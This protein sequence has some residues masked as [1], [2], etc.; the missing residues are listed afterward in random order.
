MISIQSILAPSLKISD[1]ENIKTKPVKLNSKKQEEKRI[2]ETTT[3]STIIIIDDKYVSL[4]I[5]KHFGYQKPYELNHSI[6]PPKDVDLFESIFYWPKQ[7]YTRPELNHIVYKTIKE[8]G[9]HYKSQLIY[10]LN[11]EVIDV[12]IK[13]GALTLS[14]KER[15]HIV[16]IPPNDSDTP[17]YDYITDDGHYK[18]DCKPGEYKGK[19][20]EI[21]VDRK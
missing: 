8:T 4:S 1:S 14:N 21:I 15:S 12:K 6:L 19:A 13:N 18:V 11:W 17:R 3:Y 9:Y 10:E 16:A 7:A 20:I 5:T 2:T